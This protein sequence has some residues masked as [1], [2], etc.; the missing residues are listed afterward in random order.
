MFFPHP[1]LSTSPTITLE[2]LHEFRWLAGARGKA[3]VRVVAANR[4]ENDELERGVRGAFLGFRHDS[5]FF[6]SSIAFLRVLHVGELGGLID[7]SIGSCFSGLIM[8][9][10]VFLDTLTPV[11]ELYVRLRERRQ[12]D[13]DF[14]ELVLVSLIVCPGVGTVVT[15]IVACGVPEWWHSFG[16]G[17]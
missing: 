5:R 10:V 14:P 8:V 1:L 11:F 17:W 3:V 9:C 7:P 12:W 6:G 4:A 15:M 2:L 13:S 16:Y